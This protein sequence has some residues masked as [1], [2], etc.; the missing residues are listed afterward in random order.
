M[1]FA[2]LLRFLGGEI[3]EAETGMCVEHPK[4]GVLFLHIADQPRQHRML[5]D[6]G[7]I[8]CMVDV[9]IVHFR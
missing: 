8:A 7:K 9:A 6:I 1:P 2:G 5:Q 4:A 3:V